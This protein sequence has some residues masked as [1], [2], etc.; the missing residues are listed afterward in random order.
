MLTNQVRFLR[1]P[2]FSMYGHA[3]SPATDFSPERKLR[4]DNLEHTEQ[5]GGAVLHRPAGLGVL[6]RGRGQATGTCGRHQ[7][8]YCVRG[9]AC[10]ASTLMAKPTCSALG[11]VAQ[12]DRAPDF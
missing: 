5:F 12:L 6:V 4:A 10:T 11:P 3:H 7:R 2:H 8:F 1:C 9:L